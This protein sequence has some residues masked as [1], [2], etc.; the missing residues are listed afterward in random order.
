MLVGN[1]DILFSLVSC[2][3]KHNGCTWEGEV[4]AIIEHLQLCRYKMVN[5]PKKCRQKVTQL[6]LQYHVEEECMNRDYECPMCGD[7]G[8]YSEHTTSH[9]EVCPSRLTPC[10]NDG[11]SQQLGYHKIDHHAS[12]ICDFTILECKYKDLGCET[13]VMR[14]DLAKHEEDDKHHLHIALSAL[15]DLRMRSVSTELLMS[16]AH[17]QYLP[18]ADAKKLKSDIKQGIEKIHTKC[19]SLQQD[20]AELMVKDDLSAASMKKQEEGFWQE[21]KNT[22]N[23]VRKIEVTCKSLEEN[24][25]Q[26]QQLQDDYTSQLRKED[27]KVV[28]LIKDF[29]ANTLGLSNW[30]QR[31]SRENEEVQDSLSRVMRVF[32]HLNHQIEVLSTKVDDLTSRNHCIRKITYIINSLVTNHPFAAL[33]IVVIIVI[34]FII[35]LS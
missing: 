27:T 20:V 3:N 28:Q 15:A 9:L 13:K 25:T 7:W 2:M 23:K 32:V 1:R 10:P 11:C 21:L 4:R 34:L 8:I 29:H 22:K 19:E 17:R 16:S 5:C 12:A 31:V 26:I 35:V 6:E 33:G 24:V 14:K 30:I 18:K